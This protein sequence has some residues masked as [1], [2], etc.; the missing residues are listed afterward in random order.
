[1]GTQAD[2]RDEDVA[3]IVAAAAAGDA[4]SLDALAE[5]SWD[6][7]Y[8]LAWRLLR[9]REA[10][11]DVAQEACAH[12]LRSLRDLRDATS[13]RAW[14]HRIASRIAVR[15]ARVPATE[16]IERVDLAAFAH[17]VD[18]ALDVSAAIDALGETLR[19][20]VLLFY[21]FGMPS[22]EIALALGIPDGTVRWRLAEGRRRLRSIL[23]GTLAN[24]S[25][26]R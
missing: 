4:S 2:G 18:D 24:E 8:R 1:M 21:A 26:A 6:W 14:L 22:A 20:P 7:A 9:N 13:Y 11:E 23:S 15:Y 10:A 3:A 16:S 5:R 19:V 12:A 25:V 17:D